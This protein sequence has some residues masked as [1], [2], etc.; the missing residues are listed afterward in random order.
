MQVGFQSVVSYLPQEIL[1]VEKHYAYLEPALQK[2]PSDTRTRLRLSAPKEVRRL[3]DPSAA[4]MMGLAVGQK[5]IEGSGLTPSDIDGLIVTQTGGKQFMPLLGSYLHLNLGLKCDAI[6][7]NI[8]DGNTSVLDG[9]FVAWN[10]VRSGLCR[11]V[12]L[13]AVA[14]Q[15]GG[16]TAFGVDLTDPRARNYGDGAAAAIVSSE[17]LQWQFVSYHFETHAVRSRTGGTLIADFGAVR[18]L[19]NPDLAIAAGMEYRE[20][21]YLILEDPLFEK[22]AGGPGF[23]AESLARA[24]EKA[25]LSL[26]DLE[27]IIT[28][29]VG[30]LEGQWA[31]DLRAVGLGPDVLRNLR[32]KY[33][34]IA[35]A[36]P[37]VDLAEF[38]VEGQLQRDGLVALWVPGAGVQLAVLLLRRLV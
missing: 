30:E 11:R 19:A 3:R 35:V 7:R 26:S 24:V 21:A 5:A 29:H 1:D 23:I 25:G 4:E 17:D 31:Q 14:A 16:Q 27:V 15:I 2:L 37:L 20:G 12:L 9:S 28:S 6:V 34:N 32:Q 18:P 10:F 8:V 38:S 33:G 36:D 13:V 22:V